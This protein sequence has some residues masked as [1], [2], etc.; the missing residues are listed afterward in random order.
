LQTVGLPG[1]ETTIFKAANAFLQA[2]PRNER[3]PVS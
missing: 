3:P 1:S 2:Y